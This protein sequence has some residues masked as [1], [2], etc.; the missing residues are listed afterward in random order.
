MNLVDRIVGA[1]SGGN[2]AARNPRSSAMGAGQFI[3]STWLDM[4]RR[5]RPDLAASLSRDEQLALRADPTLSRTLTQAYADE[6]G[7]A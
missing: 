2:P 5:H 1:E 4:I 7:A 3:S 6:K